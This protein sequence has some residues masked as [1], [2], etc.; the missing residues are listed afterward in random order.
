M[1]ELLA[2]S[3]EHTSSFFPFCETPP[4]SLSLSR[5]LSLT[6]HHSC[7]STQPLSWPSRQPSLACWPT[8]RSGAAW[9]GSEQ[10]R[11]LSFCFRHARH[12]VFLLSPSSSPAP[13]FHPLSAL[14][15]PFPPLL[16]RY[17]KSLSGFEALY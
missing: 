16:A 2:H 17:R 5:T 8:S 15:L 11:W 7:R 6:Q 3:L 13:L 12:L 9:P 1:A 14:L 4:P 10:V